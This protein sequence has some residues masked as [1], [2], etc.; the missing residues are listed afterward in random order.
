MSKLILKYVSY[1]C[2]HDADL[3]ERNAIRVLKHADKHPFSLM[4]LTPDEDRTL[5]FIRTNYQ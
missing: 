3:N 5:T 1:L 4:M 2:L